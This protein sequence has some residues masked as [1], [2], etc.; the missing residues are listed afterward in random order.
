MARTVDPGERTSA[1]RVLRSIL[2]GGR[3]ET[4]TFRDSLLTIGF[5]NAAAEGA[6]DRPAYVWLGTI[7]DAQVVVDGA[8]SAA[9]AADLEALRQSLERLKQCG[10]PSLKFLRIRVFERVLILRPADPIL[11]REVLHRLHIER[12]AFRSGKAALQAPNDFRRPFRPLG[13][14]LQI[15]LHPAAVERGIDPVHPDEG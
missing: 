1:E 14:R 3:L 15:D 7:S 11:H 8:A 6:A 13:K 9:V 4:V 5:F 2:P 12:D 10:S